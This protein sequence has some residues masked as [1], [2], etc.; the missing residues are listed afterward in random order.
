MIRLCENDHL[1]KKQ[2][3]G[4]LSEA[5]WKKRVERESKQKGRNEHMRL[6]NKIIRKKREPFQ[7]SYDLVKVV[8]GV[9]DALDDPIDLFLVR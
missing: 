5:M 9:T 3:D 1:M 2:E 4:L 7:T 6:T 8:H